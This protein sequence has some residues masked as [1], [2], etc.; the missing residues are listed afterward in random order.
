[1]RSS[2]FRFQ[3]LFKPLEPP[4]TFFVRSTC[5][6]NRYPELMTV[7]ESPNTL[8]LY[9]GDDAVDIVD[10]PA[11]IP[12]NLLLLDGTW[13]QAKGIYTQNPALRKLKKV[14]LFSCPIE[15][16]NVMAKGGSAYYINKIRE[17][18]R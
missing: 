12:Y 18:Q 1:M 7:L 17:R 15:Y 2:N 10:L 6:P 16:L 3:L 5:I 9:P 11:G 4:A 13:A 14:F 8:L